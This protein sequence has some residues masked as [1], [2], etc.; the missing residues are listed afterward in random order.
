MMPPYQTVAHSG[1]REQW[2]EDTLP[3]FEQAIALGADAVEQR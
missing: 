3:A 1:V 2:P